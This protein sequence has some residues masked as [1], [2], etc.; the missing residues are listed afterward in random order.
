MQDV[1]KDAGGPPIE[2]AEE[3]A[4]IGARP[5][6][7]AAPSSSLAPPTGSAPRRMELT[8]SGS[9]GEEKQVVGSAAIRSDMQST[10]GVNAT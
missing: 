4:P 5:K 9:G 1:D 3:G 8:S 10:S 6:E 2:K 7:L